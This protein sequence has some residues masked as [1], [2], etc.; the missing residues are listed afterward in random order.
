MLMALAITALIAAIAVP[1]TSNTFAMARLG[2]DARTIV[3]AVSLAKM[4]AAAKF[5]LARVYVDL[6]ARTHRIEFL[7]TG[8]TPVWV[9]DGGSTA[10][11]LNDTFGFD[12]AMAPPPNTQVAIAQAPACTTGAGAAIAGTA[13]VVFNSRGIPVDSVGAP[14]GV[15]AIYITDGSGIY[16]IT[17][18]ASGQIRLWRSQFTGAPVWVQQ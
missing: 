10:L 11:S 3:N 17:L 18:S 4:R 5:T 13:C 12:P 2:G 7:Q 6:A 14:T 16:G 1:F 8:V 9:P 15:N